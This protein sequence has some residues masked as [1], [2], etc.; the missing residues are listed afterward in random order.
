L[1]TEVVESGPFT[2]LEQ[3]MLPETVAAERRTRMFGHYNAVATVADSVGAL[4]AGGPAVL[5]RAGVGVGADQRF[6]IILVPAGLLGA[7]V[8]GSLSSAVEAPPARSLRR[9]PLERSRR[10]VLRLA[11][12]FA[13]DSFGG[14]FAVQSFW[15][16]FLRASSVWTA[17]SW[18]WC[19]SP[20]AS[21]KRARSWRQP[22]SANDLGC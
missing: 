11:G 20:S 9:R 1:S 2:S 8:A 19:S 17:D 18:G 15:V 13:L 5:R 12:L 22:G 21:Y 6:F 14:G 10:V 4:A 7:F 16:F 3:A